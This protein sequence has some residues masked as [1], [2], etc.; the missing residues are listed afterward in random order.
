MQTYIVKVSGSILNISTVHLNG[1]WQLIWRYLSKPGLEGHVVLSGHYSIPQGC[2]L[3]TGFTGA[4]LWTVCSSLAKESPYIFSNK[5]IHPYGRV[6]IKWVS[7]KWGLTVYLQCSPVL[8]PARPW[9]PA[10]KLCFHWHQPNLLSSMDIPHQNIGQH[11]WIISCLFLAEIPVL[12]LR[13][14]NLSTMCWNASLQD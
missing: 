3:N 6:C 10:M 11:F 5:S 9:N 8:L 14:Q 4:E 7:V 12:Y 13:L 1:I 2:P